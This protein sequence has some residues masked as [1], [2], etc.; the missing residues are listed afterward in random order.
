MI[1]KNPSLSILATFVF[2]SLASAAQAATVSYSAANIS[3]NAWTY[4]YT[5]ANDTLGANLEEFTVFFDLGRYANL[6][7]VTSPADWD[8]L[9][10]Q[11]DPGVPA[12]GFFDSLALGAGIAPAASLSGFVVSFDY[13]G[14]GTP[15]A[16]PF[17]IVNPVTF[18]T[19]ESG[20][21]TVVPLPGTLWLL[22]TGV[23]SLVS[24]GRVAR[25]R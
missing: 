21:T 5:V 8:S 19:L 20:T 11:P 7:V 3:A 25:R 18:E 13:L 17:D 2:F 9:V 15:G 16:Q 1:H 6:V 14:S 10:A 23:A 22:L 24:L 12:S 4:T